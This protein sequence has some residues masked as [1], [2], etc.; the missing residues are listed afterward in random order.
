MPVSNPG[1][2]KTIGNSLNKELPDD[3][4][5]K[6]T[7]ATAP[8][9]TPPTATT[10]PGT[11][12]TVN[13]MASTAGQAAAPVTPM[14]TAAL[15]GTTP[16][17]AKMAGTPAQTAAGG[18][19]LPA[20]A[21]AIASPT[22]SGKG[23]SD[24]ARA[25]RASE[26]QKAQFDADQA[27]QQQRR[28]EL[29]TAYGDVG[30]G[31]DNM[32][33]AALAQSA[34]NSMS[35]LQTGYS[36]AEDKLGQLQG[37]ATLD[38]NNKTNII[39]AAQHLAENIND[40]QAMA[41]V[42]IML[43]Q[44]G[45]KGL[46]P[47]QIKDQVLNQK[48][49]QKATAEQVADSVKLDLASLQGFGIDADDLAKIGLTPEQVEGM[50]LGDFQTKLNDAMKTEY[51]RADSIRTQL[52]DPNLPPDVRKQLQDELRQLGGAGG[53][54]S[55]AQVKQIEQEQIAD[56]GDTI[57]VGGEQMTVEQMLGD[58]GITSI[59]TKS[60]EDPEYAKKLKE[61]FPQLA[62]F[63]EKN[64][65]ALEKA[66]TQLTGTAQTVFDVQQANK[67]VRDAI[68][69][70]GINATDAAAIL[71]DLYSG[72]Q[73]SISKM[74]PSS[75]GVMQM[76]MNPSQYGLDATTPEGKQRLST[77]VSNLKTA[78]KALPNVAKDL[79]RL[80]PDELVKTGAM[81][82]S[83]KWKDFVTSTKQ[84]DAIDSGD[85]DAI[86][87]QLFGTGD[88]QQA[89]TA[90]LTAGAASGR[91]AGQITSFLD[92]DQDGKVD[93]PED[94]QRRLKEKGG[95]VSLRDLVSGKT[96]KPI[97]TSLD[98]KQK[99]AAALFS[100]PKL[101]NALT[102][103]VIDPKEIDSSPWT[104]KEMQ[105]L[106]SGMGNRVSPEAKKSIAAKM[107]ANADTASNKLLGAAGTQP[108]GGSDI[109]AYKVKLEKAL[110]EAKKDP[111]SYNLPMIQE[112][113]K[114]ADEQYFKFTKPIGARDRSQQI[115]D[116]EKE[117]EFVRKNGY[118][119]SAEDQR[120]RGK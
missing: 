37:W 103:G 72:D 49:T 61:Q 104:N 110:A 17:Q 117:L 33:K 15:A 99:E 30:L 80:S 96:A 58:E 8:A 64:K 40:P 68:T 107:Q 86:A 119:V 88:Y 19:G 102:D 12:P 85:A 25:D 105:A 20:A 84:F 50:T 83:P 57:D 90:A 46:T 4:R 32:I 59:I 75:S 115:A 77:T 2:T 34:N 113:L 94:I 10:P 43:D 53:Y 28:Q 52:S 11:Q 89:L 9:A 79:V 18:A 24:L 112:A 63:V 23:Q 44:A 106:L 76:F 41:D 65:G 36:V 87:K 21:P 38:D 6:P 13:A 54:Q 69:A 73:F 97:D 31:V 56:T 101:K 27:Q 5:R 26:L 98:P 47:Q 92:R 29:Q 91:P 120:K 70:S 3:V 95:N 14:G 35:G 55:T 45:I 81:E 111:S 109:V 39:N 118:Y 114:K 93:P 1:L 22:A 82:N 116:A 42:Q 74:D 78:V 100:T 60:L 48:S 7:S 51:A 108:K 67:E 62:E 71:G 66:A 16:D